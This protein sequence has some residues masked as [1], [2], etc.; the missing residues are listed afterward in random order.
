MFVCLFVAC[1]GLS[2]VF[3]LSTSCPTSTAAIVLVVLVV[4][5]AVLVVLVVVVIVVVVVVA[6]VVVLVVETCDEFLRWESRN[7]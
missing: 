4:V 1:F 5:F 2:F 7:G 3:R 6:V